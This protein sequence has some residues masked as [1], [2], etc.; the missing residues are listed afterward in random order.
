MKGTDL[1]AVDYIKTEAYDSFHPDESFI[2]RTITVCIKVSVPRL[3]YWYRDI[4]LAESL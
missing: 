3:H 2:C 1:S 4:L